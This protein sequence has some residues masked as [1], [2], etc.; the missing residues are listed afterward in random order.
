[1]LKIVSAVVSELGSPEPP[2]T[3]HD[4]QSPVVERTG[5]DPVLV[6]LVDL[7]VGSVTHP[8]QDFELTLV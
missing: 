8:G 7:R 5:Y 2:V 1:M 4:D 6:S 3:C